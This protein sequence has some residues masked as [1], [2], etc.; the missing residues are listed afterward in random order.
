MASSFVLAD[1]T[2]A[3][4]LAMRVSIM[5]GFFQPNDWWNIDH[6]IRCRCCIPWREVMGELVGG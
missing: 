6:F 2:Y 1:L 4:A 3:L 5:F